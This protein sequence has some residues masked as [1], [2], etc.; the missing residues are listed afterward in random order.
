MNERIKDKIKEIEQFLD[1]LIKIRPNNLKSYSKDFMKKA[2]CERY[3][4][5]IIEATNDLA[6]LVIKDQK[7]EFPE[8]DVQA[9]DII[10]DEKIIKPGLAVKLKD[11]KRMRNI[12]AHE[13]GK[14]DDEIVFHA[15][16]EELEKDIKEFVKS[17]KKVIK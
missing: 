13:Y 9:F 12:L 5:R 2:A 7:L 17:V 11:A 3:A 14:V 10:S 6:F 4:E 8:E 15:I 16:K 1:E